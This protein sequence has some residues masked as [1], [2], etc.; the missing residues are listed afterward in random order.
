MARVLL[1]VSGV[2][3]PRLQEKIARGLRPRADFIEMARVLDADLMD[4]AAARRRASKLGRM[5]EKIG[6]M[7]LVLAWACFQSR[8]AYDVILTDS[9]GV[10]IPFALLCQRFGRAAVRHLQITHILS[11][12]KKMF[13]FDYFHAQNGIDTFF[14]YSAWQKNFIQARWHVPA[15]H[16]VHIPFQVDTHF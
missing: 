3:E 16:V 11:V 10:G 14:V 2:I 9:E 8:H 1:T 6:G 13:F 15:T 4:Y 12:P 7:N 5:L